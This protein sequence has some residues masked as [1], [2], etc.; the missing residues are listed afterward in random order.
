MALGECCDAG[1]KRCRTSGS[2][3]EDR[4]NRSA[5]IFSA[6]PTA[7]SCSPC[8]H[9]AAEL[10]NRWHDIRQPPARSVVPVVVAYPRRRSRQPRQRGSIGDGRPA[11]GDLDHAIVTRLLMILENVSGLTEGEAT[12]CPTT[13]SSEDVTV[14]RRLF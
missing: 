10:Q 9:W 8:R 2:D 3:L 11:A 6:P 12:T 7:L 5:M 13:G 4:E 14:S 1:A